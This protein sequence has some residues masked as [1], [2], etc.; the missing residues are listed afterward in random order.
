[1]TIIAITQPFFF[2]GEAEAIHH[3]FAEGRIDLLH[4]RKPDASAQQCRQ[5]LSDIP[6][7]WHGR[8]VTHSHFELCAEYNLHGCHLNHRCPT[9]PPMHH[10]SVSRSCHSLDEVSKYKEQVDYL[11]LSPIFDSISKY[12]Y[13]SAF[14]DA[15]LQKAASRGIIDNKVIALGGVT[16]QR[17]PLLEDYGFGGAAMLGAMWQ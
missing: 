2:E 4:L 15:T 11:F 8:I 12:G 17:I 7:Q 5:L 14:D 16:P 9:L 10:G 3:L 6:M 13:H 1:M